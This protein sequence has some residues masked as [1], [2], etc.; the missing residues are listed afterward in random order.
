MPIPIAA[1]TIWTV[2]SV[3]QSHDSVVGSIL[4]I[5]TWFLNLSGEVVGE[6]SHADL[7]GSEGI[8]IGIS[9]ATAGFFVHSGFA[10]ADHGRSIQLGLRCL[11]LFDFKG[12]I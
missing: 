11:S 4:G 8:C 6:F 1:V 12:F 9:N 2:T 5:G 3:Y 10:P 7:T